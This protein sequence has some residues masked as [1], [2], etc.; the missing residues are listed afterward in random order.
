MEPVLSGIASSSLPL[1]S[2]HITFIYRVF[3]NIFYFLKVVVWQPKVR[4]F[5]VL[6]RERFK[7]F[8]ILYGKGLQIN[9]Y[10]H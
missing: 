6:T 5:K 2:G 3:L 10:K 9:L 8:T 4:A 7:V 1:L